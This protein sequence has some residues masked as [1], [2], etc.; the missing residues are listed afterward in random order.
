M[1]ALRRRRDNHA[2]LAVII[3]TGTGLWRRQGYS[4]RLIA[5]LVDGVIGI[6]LFLLGVNCLV[7]RIEDV[8]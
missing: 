3:Q 5:T 2:T 1:G 8:D 6:N 7:G 4:W